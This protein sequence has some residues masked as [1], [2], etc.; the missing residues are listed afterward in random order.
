[1]KCSLFVRIYSND[2]KPVCIYDLE[3]IEA[4]R[5]TAKKAINA[6]IPEY[7]NTIV[8]NQLKPVTALNTF[9]LG[10]A[11]YTVMNDKNEIIAEKPVKINILAARAAARIIKGVYTPEYDL[12]PVSFTE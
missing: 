12:Q 7:Y 1:M 3:T 8:Y 6:A 5:A 10:T 2:K 9:V 4:N 11:V